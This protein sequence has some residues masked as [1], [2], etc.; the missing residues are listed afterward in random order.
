VQRLYDAS[1]EG[2]ARRNVG[3]LG[4]VGIAEFSTDRCIFSTTMISTQ[5]LLLQRGD[6]RSDSEAEPVRQARFGGPIVRRGRFSFFLNQGTS[7]AEWCFRDRAREPVLQFR[8][9]DSRR[10][11]ASVSEGKRE[12]RGGPANRSQ[13]IQHQPVALALLKFG[14]FR[15]G[16]YVDPVA[17]VAGT[18][19]KLRRLHSGYVL[20]DQYWPIIDHQVSRKEIVWRQSIARGSSRPFKPLPAPMSGFRNDAAV[21]NRLFC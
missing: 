6:K 15:D 7:P 10:R 21:A 13:W 19:V 8:W 18:G 4:Q 14:N 16:S 17:Q 1:S 9:I 3:S 2:A 20:E 5:Q 11:W 12:T